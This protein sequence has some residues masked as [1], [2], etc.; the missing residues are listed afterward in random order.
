MSSEGFE[1]LQQ[2]IVVSY[3]LVHIFK[4]GQGNAGNGE[5]LG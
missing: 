4:V 1:A 3:L 5:G 2:H